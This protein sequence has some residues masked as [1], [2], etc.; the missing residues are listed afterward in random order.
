MSPPMHLINEFHKYN[1]IYSHTT[2]T[3]VHNYYDTLHL[4]N[5]HHDDALTSL[6]WPHYDHAHDLI[7]HHDDHHGH[8]DHH[9][10]FDDL[11]KRAYTGMQ[12]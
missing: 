12:F 4:A 5:E 1:R 8:W 3:S 10:P 2:P 9:Y 7:D 6:D 11:D